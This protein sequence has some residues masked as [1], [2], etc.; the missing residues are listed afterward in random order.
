MDY[1][2]VVAI[3][4]FRRRRGR[5]DAGLEPLHQALSTLEERGLVQWDRAHNRYDLHPV[6]RAY[7]YGKLEDREATYAQ[8]R[9]YFEA[10][11]AE[12][13]EQAQDVADLR[14]DAGTLP[15]PAQ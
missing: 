3:N 14:R 15:C 4:P 12:D 5:H 11:P 9:S 13:T 10:L 7:A 2:A 8:V 1:D 6:V